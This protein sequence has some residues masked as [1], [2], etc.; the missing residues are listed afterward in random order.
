MDAYKTDFNTTFIKINSNNSF[1]VSRRVGDLSGIYNLSSNKLALSS[2]DKGWFNNTWTVFSV[3]GLLVLR[4]KDLIGRNLKLKFIRADHIPDYQEF[5]NS[6]VGQW[7]IYK[8]RKGSIIEKP[9][10]TFFEI[11]SMGYFKIFESDELLES[12]EAIINT[13][14]KKIIFQGENMIW[15]AWFYGR[16]LRLNNSQLGVEYSLK[17]F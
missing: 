15:S 9:R 2:N 6:V 8:I 16:E 11:N 13:R 7:K 1:S 17:R 5:E 14:H 10:S 3:K 4:G 12:G